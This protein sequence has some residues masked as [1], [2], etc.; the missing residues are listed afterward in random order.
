[1]RGPGSAPPPELHRVFLCCFW[2]AYLSNFSTILFV[3]NIRKIAFV[4]RNNHC[5]DVNLYVS[6]RSERTPQKHVCFQVSEVT[7]LYELYHYCLYFFYYQQF[8]Y[9]IRT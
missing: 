5:L 3:Y 7:F 8:V 4:F 9:N 1:M 6:E 2:S